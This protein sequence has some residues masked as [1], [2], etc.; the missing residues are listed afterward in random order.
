MRVR[1]S[2]ATRTRLPSAVWTSTRTVTPSVPIDSTPRT[3]GLLQ[4][5]LGP[6]RVVGQ[7]VDLL[8]DGGD[9]QGQ[10]GAPV[11]D[12][13]DDRLGPSPWPRCRPCGSRRWARTTPCRRWPGC[14]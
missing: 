5:D 14:W 9:G 11:D 1:S 6:R 8:G 13:V 7:G 3:C 4:Q 10:V 12:D 2:R